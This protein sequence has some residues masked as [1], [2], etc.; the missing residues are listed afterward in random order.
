[1]LQCGSCWGLICRC[2]TENSRSDLQLEAR[3]TTDHDWL[4]LHHVK[5][6]GVVDGA[7]NPLPKPEKADLWRFSPEGL[8]V[9]ADGSRVC[10]ND[11]WGGF[12]LYKSRDDAQAVFD[13]PEEHLPFLDQAVESWH[14][15]VIPY[16]H[17]GTS[18]WRETLQDEDAISVAPADPKGPLVVLTS[19]GYFDP[20]PEDADRMYKFMVGID[21]V[22][23]YYGSLPGN[24]RRGLYSGGAVDGRDG[25][26]MSIWQDD[27]AM[28]AGA[29]KNGVHKTQMDRSQGGTMFDYSS[30]TRGRIVAS[31]GAWDG[32]DPVAEIA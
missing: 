21:D 29:Y 5:F 18:G 20:G 24:I 27:K 7:N 8:P 6:N 19:A 31:K 16:A 32:A 2:I 11:A 9:E 4:T 26:T 28:M 25:C 14:A 13:A 10:A 1:M 22:L 15:L 30:F 12:A 17:R 3:M 23:E